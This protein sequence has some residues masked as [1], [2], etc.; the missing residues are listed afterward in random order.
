MGEGRC[1]KAQIEGLSSDKGL[2]EGEKEGSWNL[3]MISGGFRK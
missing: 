3:S 2:T 1:F